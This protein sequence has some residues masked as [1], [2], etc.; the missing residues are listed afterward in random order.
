MP[1]I[2]QRITNLFERRDVGLS[3]GD[4]RLWEI[5]G[6]PASSTGIT[7]SPAV[8]M[9]CS[10]SRCAILA[11]SEGVGALPIILYRRAA[12]GSKAR[13]TDHPAYPLIHD[14]AN[15]WTPSSDFVET[16]TRDAL[17]TGNAY[18]HVG[19]VDGRVVEMVR[20]DP[21]AITVTVDTATGEPVYRIVDG[22]SQRF[23]DRADLFHLK[24][25]G[26]SGIVGD[27]PVQAA[28]QAIGLGML[29]EQHAARLFAKSARPSGVLKFPNKLGGEVAARIKASWQGAHSGDNAGATAVLEEGGEWH[30]TA[31]T[32]VDS[33]F[34][35]IWKHT[36]TLIAQH[37][38]VPPALLM[39]MSDATFNNAEAMNRSFLDH[40]LRRWLKAWEGAL[41][42][43]LLSTDER[44][45][46][47]VEFETAGFLQ[48]DT[49]GRAE[50]L[51]KYRA[52]GVMTANEARAGLNLPPRADGDQL[53]SPFTTPGLSNSG[54][55]G[56][57]Q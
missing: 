56:G 36:I 14:F 52:A 38:R 47:F 2:I 10:A 53:T 19:R 15:D 32:S 44:R 31:F 22:S 29:L 21:A 11:I 46:H 28:R 20:I 57:A 34:S 39:S 55:G 8:A 12:D 16:A 26:L 23:L 9:R 3:S 48:A 6:A 49:A 43:A 54:S 30:A 25:P 37:F 13:A 4:P 45:D 35:V 40:T 17:L 5:F 27:S 24:A 18:A 41:E 51:A 42:L 33:E 7:V 50:A 1:S